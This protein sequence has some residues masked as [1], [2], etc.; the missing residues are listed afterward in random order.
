MSEDPRKLIPPPRNEFIARIEAFVRDLAFGVMVDDW[1]PTINVIKNT[2]GEEFWES[3]GH[4]NYKDNLHKY[5]REKW[6]KIREHPA[7]SFLQVFD[8]MAE[9]HSNDGMASNERH[10][11]LTPKALSLLQKPSAPPSIFI[12]YKRSESS[13]FALLIEARLK[14]VGV[15]NPFVDKSIVAGELWEPTLRERISQAKYFVCLIGP[16]TLNSIHI[17]D[18]ITWASDAGCT[19][20]SIWHN[21]LSLGSEQNKPHENHPYFVALKAPQA[22]RVIE[23]SAIEYEKGVN[24]MLNAMGYTTY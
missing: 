11:I 20:I 13:A 12:S 14:L 22:I 9:Y 8:Y 1:P 17:Q 2:N 23:E 7:A 15:L 3:I 6:G 16:D 19:I 10:L 5:L 24:S 21:G 4:K 18:E